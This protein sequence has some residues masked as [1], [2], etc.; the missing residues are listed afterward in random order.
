MLKIHY[1]W[2]GPPDRSGRKRDILG[3]MAMM[4]ARY[5]PNCEPF[6]IDFWCLNAHTRYFHDKFRGKNFTVRGR[7]KLR[8]RSIESYL[9]S[10][11]G[12]R[13]RGFHHRSTPLMKVFNWGR[14]KTGWNLD[15][16]VRHIVTHSTRRGATVREIVNAKNI[17]SLYTMYRMGGYAMDTGVGPRNGRVN[18]RA[19]ESF[20]APR[21]QGT[22]YTLTEFSGRNCAVTQ[23]VANH[24]NVDAGYVTGPRMD[25]WTLYAPA[26]DPILL[27]GLEWYLRYWYA[28][29]NART[30]EPEGT[31]KDLC[32]NGIISTVMT[33]ICCGGNR[34]IRG[35]SVPDRIVTENTW[36]AVLEGDGAG[37]GDIGITKTYY[38]SHH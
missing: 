15:L 16:V 31:Y 37:I 4:K 9:E 17:W 13:R 18:I 22:F 28:L 35:D 30:S 23:P 5:G 20:K 8:V 7:D 27:Y 2:V 32:R 36:D 38:G 3:P 26:E 19:Y 21:D 14:Y 29:E 33:A 10:C 34:R 6:V 12:E 25:V 11:V 1:T 24:L